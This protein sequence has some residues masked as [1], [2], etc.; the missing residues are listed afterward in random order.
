MGIPKHMKDTRAYQMIAGLDE[1]GNAQ[2]LT[3]RGNA[4]ITTN[5]GLFVVTDA[6]LV[7]FQ[8]VDHR[9]L[10]VL[11]EMSKT[12]KKIEYHLSIASDTELKDQDV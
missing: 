2:E 5:E 11:E 4:V 6:G 1:D 10:S 8:M 7:K 9:A 3:F 12:L